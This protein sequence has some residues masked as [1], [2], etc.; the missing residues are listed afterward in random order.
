MFRIVTGLIL[1][2]LVFEAGAAVCDNPPR[3]RFSLI[4]Q[5]DAKKDLAGFRPL[6]DDL[7]K[8]LGKPVDAV[9]PSSYGSVV[10]GL[11]AAS[12]DL[13]M[14][15]PASYTAAKNSDPDVQ[16]FANYVSKAGPFQGEG[17]TYRSML[18]VRS[19]SKFA[20]KESLKG[21]RLALVD[22]DSTSGAVVPRKFFS[23]LVNQPIES[24]FGRVSYTGGHGKSAETVAGGRVDAAFVSSYLLSDYIVQ[25]KASKETYR[26][27]WASEPLP[28][29]PFVYRGRLCPVI[30]EKIRKVFLANKG[31]KYRGV[32]DQ[33][34]AVRFSA[35][36]D[37]D[38][39]I[40]RETLSPQR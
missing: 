40:I 7:A 12:I 27:L 11:L 9:F 33:L 32:L 15:G 18:I 28:L 34:N 24:F 37:D 16:A 26:I 5:S 13:A 20:S 30:K 31:E 25:G 8:E 23:L 39:R 6:L 3:L 29:D 35:V 10:E 17:P 19:D 2:L 14:M 21:A 38:Y 36:T 1:S 4:P 22:P